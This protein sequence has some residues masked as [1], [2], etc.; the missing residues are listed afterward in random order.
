MLLLLFAC[1]AGAVLN[2]ALLA[3]AIKQR[4]EETSSRKI[5]NVGT[6]KQREKKQKQTQRNKKTE[7]KR[8]NRNIATQSKP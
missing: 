1:A 8:K 6:K 7:K 2:A 4:K 5:K 3:L